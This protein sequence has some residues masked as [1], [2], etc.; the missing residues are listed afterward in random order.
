M[1]RFIVCLFSLLLALSISVF[2]HS[3]G[4]DSRGGHHVCGTSEYHYHHGKPAHQHPGGVC[5]YAA[6]T[7]NV[8]I[9]APSASPRTIKTDQISYKNT[10]VFAFVSFIA[11]G[12]LLFAYFHTKE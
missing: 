4:T 3:G 12:I 1:K 2:P 10:A 8:D 7:V 9:A 6:D 11:G 5:P